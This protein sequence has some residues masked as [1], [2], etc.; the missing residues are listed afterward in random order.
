MNN[1]QIL[2]LYD[3]KLTNPNGD[4]DEENRPRMDYE[5]SLN[6]VS[7]LRLKRYIRD[8]LNDKG[9]ILYVQKVDGEP[10]TSAA[11]VKEFVEDGKIDKDSFEELKNTFIDV[12]L[13]GATITSKD[14]KALTGPVQFNWGYSLNKVELL[15]SSI[16]SHFASSDTNKQ[17]AIGKDY[18][19]KYSMIAFSGVISGRRAEK[20][21]LREEDIFLLDE[22][23][24]KAIPLLAT[25]SKIGQYPRFYLRLD[26]KDTET[27]LRDLRSYIK[28]NPDDS[29]IRDVN[30]CSLDITKLVAY[31][32]ENRDSINKIYYFYDEALSL[33]NKDE[34]TLLEKALEN[35]NIIKV[36]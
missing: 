12:R 36:Q 31:L 28:L 30:E 32:N 34:K 5:R 2:Y 13:F 1:G 24:Y 4:P 17:G 9:Y 14:N 25:R 26:F 27:I 21:N 22:A 20:T 15:E 8:Y 10:V 23:L 35:F 18:R 3:A 16:T 6:L 11:R 19:V 29:S 33:K 7:D